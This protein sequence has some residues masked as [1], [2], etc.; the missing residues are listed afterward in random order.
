M[1][2]ACGSAVW[3]DLSLLLAVA[4]SI[5]LVAVLTRSR[6]RM[7]A[8]LGGGMGL[9][10]MSTGF[11]RYLSAAA[12]EN[13]ERIELFAAV[14]IGA[15][16]FA[17]SA[18]TLCR[19]HGVLQLDAVA[20]PG[21]HVVNLFS[22]LLCGWLGYGFITEHAQ[23]DGLAA[24]L[25]AGALAMAMGAHLMLSREY[26]VDPP[27][28]AGRDGCALRTHSFAARSDGVTIGKPG[29][30]ANIEWHGG[31]EQRWALREVVPSTMGVSTYADR[32]G[33]R[34]GRRGNGRQRDCARKCTHK[35]PAH[36]TTR[37]DQ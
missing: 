34:D 16:I 3:M 5:A 1:P 36:F 35:R 12:C 17:T 21:H 31:D 23:P 10:V 2:Q 18:I 14:S 8:L 22:L 15:L 26:S 13:T 4:V 19:L 30:L 11:T 28:R 32:R 33:G 20:R 37:A 24:L 6:P 9:A 29:L 27:H 25:A 7:V